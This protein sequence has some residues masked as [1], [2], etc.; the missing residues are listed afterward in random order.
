M[1]NLSCYTTGAP[2][3]KDSHIEHS[4]HQ[5]HVKHPEEPGLWWSGG[6][7]VKRF[8]A[9]LSESTPKAV[10][11]VIYPSFVWG[12]TGEFPA[13]GPPIQNRRSQNSPQKE[14]V[15]PIPLSH[16]S[17]A[18]VMTASPVKSL[19]NRGMETN[20]LGKWW[21]HNSSDHVF[22][23]SIWG[24]KQLTQVQELAGSSANPAGKFSDILKRDGKVT[25]CG[26]K[27]SFFPVTQ[28]AIR[29]LWSTDHA[30]GSRAIFLFYL[31]IYFVKHV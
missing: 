20:Q 5:A 11:L 28:I 1:T 3:R 10:L 15:S 27:S 4:T 31:F 22:F 8:G 18:T 14:P 7:S 12:K 24:Q 16:G 6:Q 19:V 26:L 21:C 13:F 30:G 29:N 25:S 23:P 9:D 2:K 17:S